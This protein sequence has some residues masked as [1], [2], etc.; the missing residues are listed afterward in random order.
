[1][2]AKELMHSPVQKDQLAIIRIEGMH[3][4]QCEKQIQQKLSALPGVR[5]VEV[6]F[7]SSQASILYSSMQL[8]ADDLVQAIQLAGYKVG[9]LVNS[10][11]DQSIPEGQ[12]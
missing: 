11:V 10:P 2:F 7:P 4:H 3:C 1:M 8:K 6:D 9:G 12:A 5:E